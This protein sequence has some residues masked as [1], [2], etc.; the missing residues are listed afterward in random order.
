M[1]R[2]L[3]ATWEGGG[4][5]LPMLLVARGL[6]QQGHEALAISDACNAPDAAALGVPFQSWRQAPS[7]ADRDPAGD[8]LKD[9]Q[10]TSPMEVIQGLTRGLMCGP[11]GRYA[12]DVCVAIDTFH[13]DVVVS[14]E[15]LF[16]VM[17]AAEAKT[18]PLALF[19]ANVWSLPTIEGA[20]PFGAGAPLADTEET[21]AFYARIDAATRCAYQDELATL[22]AARAGLG[23]AP[24][25]DLFDQLGAARRILLATSRAFDYGQKPPEPYRYVGPYLADPAWTG[26]WAP[27]WPADDRRPLALVSFS[28]MYQGQEPALRRVIEALAG[29]D[30]RTLVTLGPIL[31]PADFPAPP[32]IWVVPHAPHSRIFPEAAVVITHAGHA[33][34]LRP[35]MAGVPLVCLPL[36]RD[37]PDNA[38]RVAAR[39]AGLRLP[40]DAS[41]DAIAAAVRRVLTEPGFKVAAGTL[42]AE[43][44]A[45]WTAR[46]AERELIELAERTS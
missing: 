13:P 44:E 21:Q 29:L 45:D 30:M 11:A 1:A 2:F 46:S 15:L 20:P 5:V 25:A 33:S 26:D 41:T 9:W 43:I 22:N 8:P 10:A 3:F 6:V 35:L 28:S 40:A 27:P 19:A 42:G 12:A 38:A 39:G 36:G 37:Q 34:A 24:L 4:H 31:S 14:Q 18:V 17:M 7:R 16:G 32:N 23:L